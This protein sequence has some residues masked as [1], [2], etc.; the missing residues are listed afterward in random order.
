MHHFAGT[1]FCA[2]IPVSHVVI[3]VL[4]DTLPM[5]RAVVWNFPG[6]GATGRRAPRNQFA[7]HNA[8]DCNKT[9][10][11]RSQNMQW[12]HGFRKWQGLRESG[13]KG[14]RM[15]LRLAEEAVLDRCSLR[16]VF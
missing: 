14:D 1:T 6:G 9:T 10:Y 2:V 7:N 4:C 15:A 3:P 12:M 8:A 11:R 13:R 5:P 16:C